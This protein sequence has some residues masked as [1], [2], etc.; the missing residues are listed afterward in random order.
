[1][2]VVCIL[3]SVPGL[4]DSV[5]WNVFF[6]QDDTRTLAARFIEREVPAGST[7]LV[8]P[9]SAPIRQSREGLIE[10]LPARNSNLAIETTVGM[11]GRVAP[12]GSNPIR[13]GYIH[14]I[15][16]LSINRCEKSPRGIR[17]QSV[18]RPELISP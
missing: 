15:S 5:R 13:K 10:A 9:Y 2:A 17:G 12:T 4:S 7:I 14:Q 8:Q 3:A 6:G 16:R 18:G 1:M 11:I